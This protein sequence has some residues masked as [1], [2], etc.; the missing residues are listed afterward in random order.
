[1]PAGAQVER[2]RQPGQPTTNDDHVGRVENK[3]R[4]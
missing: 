4:G 2:R 1:V 3:I